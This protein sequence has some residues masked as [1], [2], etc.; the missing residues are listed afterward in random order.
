[1]AIHT[2]S[3]CRERLVVA[4]FIAVNTPVTAGLKLTIVIATVTALQASI[5]AFFAAG[6]CE[7]VAAGSILASVSA[8]IALGAITIIAAL[9]R[10]ERRVATE[11][12]LAVGRAEIVVSIVAIVALFK[13]RAGAEPTYAGFTLGAVRWLVVAAG[14]HGAIFCVGA[15]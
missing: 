2:R 9:A 1:L 14:L 7:P 3:S 4:L 8:G 6:L 13:A 12:D 10:V 11:G 5:V 15:F